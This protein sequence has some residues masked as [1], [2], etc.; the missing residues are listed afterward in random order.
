MAKSGLGKE[1]GQRTGG[2]MIAEVAG[3]VTSLG[4]LLLVKHVAGPERMAVAKEQIAM[5]VMLPILRRV[6][7]GKEKFQQWRERTS[8]RGEDVRDSVFGGDGKP[9]DE[10]TELVDKAG[11]ASGA[12]VGNAVRKVKNVFTSER[13]SLEDKARKYADTLLDFTI[14]APVGLVTRAWAQTK[15]DKM[16]GAPDITARKWSM[17]GAPDA[18][19]YAKIPEFV[20]S[21]VALVGMNSVAKG[22]AQAIT[23][24]MEKVLTGVGVEKVSAASMA[25]Y[26][27]YIQGPNIIGNV[28]NVGYVTAASRKQQNEGTQVPGR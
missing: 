11:D 18:Y 26:L 16:L 10:A 24:T 3:I 6:D 21:N 4:S 25:R 27:T 1:I 17:F 15:A 9:L 28:V 14:M 22:P 13:M 19:W 8:K 5:H 20:A 23:N 12:T 7:G 2:V